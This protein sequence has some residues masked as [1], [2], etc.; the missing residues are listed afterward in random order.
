[1]VHG[2]IIVNAFKLMFSR[3]LDAWAPLFDQ[4]SSFRRI[5]KYLENWRTRLSFLPQNPDKATVFQIHPQDFGYNS[6][7][8]KTP[9]SGFVESYI[10]KS[11]LLN[12]LAAHTENL[13]APFP[14]FLWHFADNRSDW[15]GL[16]EWLSLGLP[17][18]WPTGDI[19]VRGHREWYRR[20]SETLDALFE[21]VVAFRQVDWPSLDQKQSSEET[22]AESD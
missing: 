7:L 19:S 13:P 20:M 16:A 1:M 3:I 17:F 21:F 6:W 14:D 18:G 10:V 22:L 12:G 11:H 4:L 5:Q 2:I 15:R 9:D 8:D